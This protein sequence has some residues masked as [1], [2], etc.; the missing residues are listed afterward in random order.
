M[1]MACTD[2]TSRAATL[3]DPPLVCVL[4]LIYE[5]PVSSN[6][7]E[8]TPW[9]L[10]ASVAS[11]EGRRGRG[12]SLLPLLPVLRGLDPDWPEFVYLFYFK[13]WLNKKRT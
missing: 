6:K 4:A 5:C 9:S 10:G 13:V 7:L 12:A 8:A 11:P 1:N 2:F 3:F